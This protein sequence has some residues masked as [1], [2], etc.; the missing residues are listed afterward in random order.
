M[1]AVVGVVAAVLLAMVCPFA[2]AL[3]LR[4][5][6]RLI[7]QGDAASPFNNVPAKE[8]EGSF[9]R[10]QCYTTSPSTLSSQKVVAYRTVSVHVFPACSMK[11]EQVY[12]KARDDF[13]AVSMVL[14][15]GRRGGEQW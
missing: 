11:A 1:P 5:D 7:P 13:P 3:A 6:L 2:D 14:A 10:G 12:S 9:G 8:E 15:G 4:P